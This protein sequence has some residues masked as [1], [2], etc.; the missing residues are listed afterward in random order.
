MK[1]VWK[2]FLKRKEKNEPKQQNKIKVVPEKNRKIKLRMELH[3]E[4]FDWYT[5]KKYKKIF[6]F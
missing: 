2:I 1:C 5:Q 3:L 6:H 4:S